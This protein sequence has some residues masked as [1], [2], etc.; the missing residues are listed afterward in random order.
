MKK[1][2]NQYRN[3][4]SRLLEG[5]SQSTPETNDVAFYAYMTKT[6]A[7]SPHHTLIFDHVE[8]NIGQAYNQ[9]SGAFTVPISGVYILS[10]TVFP[11]GAGSWASVELTVNSISRG[12]IFIDS[13]SGDPDYTGC[14]GFAVLALKQG[15]VCFVRVH[16]TYHSVGKIESDSVMR[17]SFSGVKV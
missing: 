13:S 8:T 10:Y 11:N 5:G 17:S 16:S 15:D 1:D 6:E 4:S 12:A 3:R 9:H 7:I 2:G 14:T